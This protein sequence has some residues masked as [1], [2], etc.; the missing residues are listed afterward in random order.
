MAEKF[1][2]TGDLE[3]GPVVGSQ[4]ESSDASTRESKELV[5]NAGEKDSVQLLPSA[6]SVHGISVSFQS[7][8]VFC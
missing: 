5:Q 6:R 1:Q 4:K 3:Q 2:T 7:S 8:V